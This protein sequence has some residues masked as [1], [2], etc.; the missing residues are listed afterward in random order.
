MFACLCEGLVKAW[1][2]PPRCYTG[3]SVSISF[4]HACTHTDRNTL[5][6]SHVHK[7]THAHMPGRCC[8]VK[9]DVLNLTSG[10]FHLQPVKQADD[11]APVVCTSSSSSSSASVCDV[12]FI[13]R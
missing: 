10:I 3:V 2:N 6:L 12:V 9:L 8:C 11:A 5:S 1:G 4:M 7:Y 13:R